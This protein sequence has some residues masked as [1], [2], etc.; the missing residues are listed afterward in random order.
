M[1]SM[2]YEGVVWMSKKQT[3][4][5]KLNFETSIKE[6]HKGQEDGKW[7]IVEDGAQILAGYLDSKVI[8]TVLN[9]EQTISILYDLIM[10]DQEGSTL[11]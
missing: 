9:P 8:D 1:K 11:L 2:G 3:Q 6:K 10:N 4:E 7:D 5:A